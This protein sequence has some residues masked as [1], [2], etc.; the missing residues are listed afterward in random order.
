MELFNF[1][2]GIPLAI[3]MPIFVS[4]VVLLSLGIYVGA[5]RFISPSLTKEHERAGRVL[6]RTSAGLLALILSFTFANDRVLYYQ[7]KDSLIS[8]ASQLVDMYMDLREYN[9]PEAKEINKDILAY[10]DSVVEEGWV[11]DDKSPFEAAAMREF[12]S[13]YQKVH[14]LVPK[15]KKQEYLL[16]DLYSDLD[17]LSDY[18]QVR[19]YQTN[20]DGHYVFYIVLVGLV[21][22]NILYGVYKPD[23]IKMLFL[24]L[25]SGFI[26]TIIYF[27]LIMSQ[28]L[29]GPLQIRPE[30]FLILKDAIEAR[31]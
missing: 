5:Y 30:P 18:M 26:A 8:E 7:I 11:S 13:I 23:R 12:R 15:N 24:A 1:L 2:F 16:R 4:M 9:S 27:M 28:P 25:Y 10:V 17:G 21:V 14:D 20:N 19:I 6:F 22:I 3:G 29:K 31:Q